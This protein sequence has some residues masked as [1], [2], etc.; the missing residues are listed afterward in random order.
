MVLETTL[1]LED[2][3]AAAG[4]AH[5]NE[6]G[7]KQ[8]GAILKCGWT[9]TK[10]RIVQATRSWKPGEVILAEEP[11]HIVQEEEKSAA[12]Q[13]LQRLCTQHE[14][15]FDY[16]PLWYWC[17]IQSLTS[18]QVKGATVK[19]C[20]GTTK[21]IQRNLLL[22]HHEDADDPSSAAEIIVRELCP[23][24]DPMVVENL[25]Q[26]WV[27][28][29]FEYSDDPQGYSTYF[30]SSFMSHSCHP[31]AVWHY[32]G[33]NHVLRA[34]REINPGDEVCIS[35]LPEAQLLQSAPVRRMELHETKRFWC[36]CERCRAGETDFS[37]GQVCPRCNEG[38]VFARTPKAGP[39]KDAALLVAHFSEVSCSSCKHVLT[40]SER[41]KFCNQEAKL[42]EI[43]DKYSEEDAKEPS[44]AD[45]QKAEALIDERFSQHVLA[46][47]CWERLCR[48]YA[49]KRRPADQMRLLKRRV[50]FH[51]A[52]YPGLSGAHAW[53]LE[54][55]GDCAARGTK[56]P[57]TSKQTK[58]QRS[59]AASV[60]DAEAALGYYGD[61]LRVLRLMFGAEHEYVTDVVQKERRLRLFAETEVKTQSQEAKPVVVSKV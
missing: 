1:V 43:V 51:E 40:Q 8:F 25:I 59:A 47:L 48:F 24:A 28:N 21:E 37:R 56:G 23:N 61:A 10:G 7:A 42:Q 60:E 45:M 36:T 5:I 31:N 6:H 34:R 33:A 12:F 38:T 26:V 50:A 57:S 32:D 52:A 18:E 17:A 9:A 39:A 29:C 4:V 15:D 44:L 35:Y 13:K 41:Q 54:S 49:S 22:L 46:D 19:G 11:L 30:F 20:K 53:A 58:T 55:L 27:L 16:E 3:P 2:G 14:D